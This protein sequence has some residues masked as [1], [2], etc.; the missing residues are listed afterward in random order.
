MLHV[1][2]VPPT[3]SVSRGR[4]HVPSKG[5]GGGLAIQISSVASQLGNT[6]TG[7]LLSELNAKSATNASRL[8]TLRKRDL[9]DFGEPKAV[10]FTPKTEAM[11]PAALSIPSGPTTPE[12]TETAEEELEQDITTVE[13]PRIPPPARTSPPLHSV[14]NSRKPPHFTASLPIAPKQLLPPRPTPQKSQRKPTPIPLVPQTRHID[15]LPM[16]LPNSIPYVSALDS[17]PISPETELPPSTPIVPSSPRF[18][19]TI[20]VI[21]D[22]LDNV[23]KFQRRPRLHRT[24]SSHA[25]KSGFSF[26]FPPPVPEKERR[27]HSRRQKDSGKTDTGSQCMQDFVTEYVEMRNELKRRMGRDQRFPVAGQ[28]M[29]VTD[30]GSVYAKLE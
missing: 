6:I 1:K 20:N 18:E 17:P 8:Y 15:P 14:P 11:S 26:D 16:P 10:F 2:P 5:K 30:F 23:P 27:R 12:V 28:L 3:P 25:D 19:H 29:C 9:A 13:M 24:F 4:T 7:W 22:R 21:A